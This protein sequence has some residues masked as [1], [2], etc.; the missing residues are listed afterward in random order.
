MHSNRISANIADVTEI[1]VSPQLTVGY[2]IQR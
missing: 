2:S 1:G